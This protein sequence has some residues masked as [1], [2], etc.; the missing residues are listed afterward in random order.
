MSL[1]LLPNGKIYN[2]WV[3]IVAK[4]PQTRNWLTKPNT[5]QKCADNG[6]KNNPAAMELNASLLMADKN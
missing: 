5:K 4:T 6:N 3:S 2:V 1:K